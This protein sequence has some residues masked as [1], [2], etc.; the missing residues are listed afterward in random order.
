MTKVTVKTQQFTPVILAKSRAV[1]TWDMGTWDS[2]FWDS[3]DDQVATVKAI[4]GNPSLRTKALKA[5]VRTT[6][7][8][9]VPTMKTI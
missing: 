6:G 9:N 7:H 3:S 2:G 1:R 5:S 8:E 4:G